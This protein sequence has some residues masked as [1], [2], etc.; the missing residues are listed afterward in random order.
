MTVITGSFALALLFW[1]PLSI[2]QLIGGIF[3]GVLTAALGLRQMRSDKAI[4]PSHM[5]PSFVLFFGAKEV[6]GW[7]EPEAGHLASVHAFLL[8]LAAMGAVTLCF[9]RAILRRLEKEASVAAKHP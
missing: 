2:S 7:S 8:T 1:H 4:F 6:A 3:V 9:G 5:L